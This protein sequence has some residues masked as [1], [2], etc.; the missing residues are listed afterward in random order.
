MEKGKTNNPNG[1]PLGTPNKITAEIRT[2]LKNFFFAELE[3]LPTY[4]D[5][6]D[7]EKRVEILLK[8]MPYVLPKV[9][10]VGDKRGEP[11]E[12]IMESFEMR[13]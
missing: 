5:S 9:H 3:K 11:D 2:V 10:D 1:R 8:L 6:L 7:N 4:L 13:N 12:F